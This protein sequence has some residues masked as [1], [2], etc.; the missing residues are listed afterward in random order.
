LAEQISAN[1]LNLK[2]NETNFAKNNLTKSLLFLPIQCVCVQITCQE[3]H[4]RAMIIGFFWHDLC[5]PYVNCIV[6]TTLLPELR[7]TNAHYV[8]A[9][10]K[11]IIDSDLC[12][13]YRLHREHNIKLKRIFFSFR[14]FQCAYRKKGLWQLFGVRLVFFPDLKKEKQQYLNNILK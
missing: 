8:V 12:W 1:G 5:L 6:K 7:R 13:I 2:A 4:S 9:A 10:I 14:L 11:K 3:P